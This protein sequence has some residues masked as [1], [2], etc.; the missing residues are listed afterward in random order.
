MAKVVDAEACCSDPVQCVESGRLR[1]VDKSAVLLP[2][3]GVFTK[4]IEA[5]G[6]G[7]PSR[8]GVIALVDPLWD[9]AKDADL[10]CRQTAC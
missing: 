10:V 9:V 4:E 8:V 7:V 1:Q 3:S 5:N 2:A 6:P